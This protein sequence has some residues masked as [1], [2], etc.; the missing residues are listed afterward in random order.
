MLFKIECKYTLELKGTEIQKVIQKDMF[1]MSASKIKFINTQLL[2]PICL[3]GVQP[4]LTLHILW[5]EQ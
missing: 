5:K 1:C 4:L 3:L 2:D